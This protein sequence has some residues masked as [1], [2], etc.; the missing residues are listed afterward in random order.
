VTTHGVVLISD[1]SPAIADRIRLQRA[2]RSPAPCL[3][4]PADS[5]YGRLPPV[6]TPIRLRWGADMCRSTTD[7]PGLWRQDS[8]G[9]GRPTWRA[10]CKPWGEGRRAVQLREVDRV[11][12]RHGGAS[13]DAFDN[14]GVVTAQWW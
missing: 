1:P 12:L 13:R 11:A 4:R 7:A 3:T 9:A 6:Q 14:F 10:P 8:T 5:A 2:W